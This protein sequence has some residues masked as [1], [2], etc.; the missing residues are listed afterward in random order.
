M[1]VVLCQY[2]MVFFDKSIIVLWVISLSTCCQYIIV[3][4]NIYLFTLILLFVGLRCRDIEIIQH[5]CYTQREWTGR[6]ILCHWK[7]LVTKGRNVPQFNFYNLRKLLLELGRNDILKIIDYSETNC[8]E[9]KDECT[10]FWQNIIHDLCVVYFG[11]TFGLVCGYK[12]LVGCNVLFIYVDNSYKAI[13]IKLE[14]NM[15]QWE[16]SK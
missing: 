7:L 6:V 12:I 16:F 13:C 8:F 10:S 5:F 9:T 3:F 15:F 11:T 1:L 2:M 4:S 14:Q